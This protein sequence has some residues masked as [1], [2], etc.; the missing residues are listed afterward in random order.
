M[1]KGRVENYP[2]DVPTLRRQVPV[3]RVV[4]LLI[5]A[6]AMYLALWHCPAARLF[7]LVALGRNQGVALAG[8]M[9]GEREALRRNASKSPGHRASRARG[10]A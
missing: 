7:A 4:N 8:A 1:Y 10:P 2:T 6:P 5:T 9:E 3:R